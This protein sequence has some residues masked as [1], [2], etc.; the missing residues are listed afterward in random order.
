MEVPLPCPRV[1]SRIPEVMRLTQQP[2]PSESVGS[3]VDTAGG[4]LLLL[5][6]TKVSNSQQEELRG[7]G[8]FHGEVKVVRILSLLQFL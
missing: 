4:N 3:Y 6:K 8:G 1:D 7:V 5:L 2:H